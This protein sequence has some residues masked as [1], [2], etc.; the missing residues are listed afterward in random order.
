MAL[1]LD[2]DGTL[3]PIAPH[4]DDVQMGDDVRRVLEQ[5]LRAPD[6][7]TV[8]VSGRPLADLR[9]IVGIEGLTYVGDHGFQLEGPGLTWSHPGIA[10]HAKALERA[11]AELEA[12]AI[13][14]AW[15]ERKA[16]TLAYHVR[17]VAEGRRTAAMLAA[18]KI[19]R[20]GRLAVIMG[21]YGVEGIPPL[22]WDKGQAIL[23]VLRTRFG[24]DWSAR[25]A[26]LVVGDDE[27]DELAFRALRGIGRS[28]R[29][30]EPENGQSAADFTVRGPEDVIQLVR[31]IASGA[32]RARRG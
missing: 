11:A 7:D 4:P 13:P 2:L 27:T 3:V 23:S 5:A 9:R 1:F 12:L 31:W 8:I 18:E 22:G 24:P 6:L 20:R 15:V 21:R 10:Q 16:A 28:V 14:G 19:L 25:V 32:A 26:P 17:A 29:V 30:G